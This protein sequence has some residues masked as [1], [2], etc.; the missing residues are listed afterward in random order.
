MS[1]IPLLR[2][3]K[4]TERYM[5]AIEADM[6]QELDAMKRDKSVDVAEWIRQ[7]IREN[8]SNLRQSVS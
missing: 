5:L 6:K 1:D 8:L 3:R 7:L 4:L 2:K